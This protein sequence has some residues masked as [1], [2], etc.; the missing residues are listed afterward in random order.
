MLLVEE[1]KVNIDNAPPLV[2][3]LVTNILT[4][5]ESK[6]LCNEDSCHKNRGETTI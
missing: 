2:T 3:L 5:V 1:Q 6:G 4:D